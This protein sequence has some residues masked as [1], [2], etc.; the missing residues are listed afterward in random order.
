MLKRWF[1][2]P[3]EWWQFWMPGSG[4]GGGL[5][6]AAVMISL[7]DLLVSIFGGK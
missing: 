5:F 1:F 2:A 3:A 7:V 6:A 4:L